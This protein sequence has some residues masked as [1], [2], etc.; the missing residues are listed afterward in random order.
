MIDEAACALHDRLAARRRR[1]GLLDVAYR[2][3]ATPVGTLLLAATE[4]GL[5]RVAYESRT[6]SRCWPPWLRRSARASCAPRPGWTRWPGSWRSTS[7]RRRHRFDVPLDFRLADGFR[8]SVLRHLPDI[9]YGQT[10]SYAQVATAAGSPRAV[11]AVG[12]ACARNPLPVVVP[13]HRVIRS[14]GSLGQYRAERR[15]RRSCCT[16]RGR[17]ETPAM[18]NGSAS[19]VTAGFESGWRRRAWRSGWPPTGDRRELDD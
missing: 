4:R 6:T 13:C 3:L 14:D 8:R 9:G 1:D 17:H 2:E 7:R 19:G 18:G 16:W 12:T 10:A 15:P 5:V 11:R